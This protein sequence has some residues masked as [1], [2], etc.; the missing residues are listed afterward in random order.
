VG[1][2]PATEKPSDIDEIDLPEVQ[3][4]LINELTGTGKPVVLVMLQGRPRII[5]EIED[6]V[7][8]VIMAYLPGNE[9]GRA[10][11]DVLYG[12]INASGNL[13]YTYPRFSG[14]L[15][16]YD[17]PLSDERDVNFGLDGFKPQYEFGFGLSYTT[18]GYSEISINADSVYIN[19]TIE[20]SV[21]VTN[22]G[23]ITGKEAVLLFVSDEVASISLPVKQLRKF[24][25]I[26]LQP[27][28]TKTIKFS[29]TSDDL[30]FVGQNNK[31]ITETG[32]F[33]IAIGNQTKRFYLYN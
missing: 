14:S 1:E 12:V 16:T 8:A 9:G 27:G 26:E 10:I 21:E 2:K 15:W 31:W 6:D 4:Q 3:Q 13:P 33:T 19:N 25:K 32:Y 29:L 24:Q 20:V 7:K 30:K 18:F 17:H 23:N 11:A 5:R 28:E 22:T